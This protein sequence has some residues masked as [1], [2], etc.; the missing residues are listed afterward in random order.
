MFGIEFVIATFAAI[1]GVRVKICL[2]KTAAGYNQK[3]KSRL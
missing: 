1:T 2:K 3:L